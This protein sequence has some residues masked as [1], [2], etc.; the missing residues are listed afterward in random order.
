MVKFRVSEAVSF[1][2]VAKFI[3]GENAHKLIIILLVLKL[4][5]QI[6]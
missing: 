6:F 2:R 5:S 3:H 1:V 4:L